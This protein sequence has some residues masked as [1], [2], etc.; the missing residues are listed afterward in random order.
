MP[1]PGP[2]TLT[3]SQLLREEGR[4][5]SQFYPNRK[6][7]WAREALSRPQSPL[8]VGLILILGVQVSTQ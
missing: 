5:G 8:K 1:A 4:V 6:R 7:P 2:R 3:P